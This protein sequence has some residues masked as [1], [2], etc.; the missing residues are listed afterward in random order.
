LTPAPPIVSVAT[1]RLIGKPAVVLGWTRL[2]GESK[3]AIATFRS[4]VYATCPAPID[5]TTPIAEL[6]SALMITDQAPAMSL[7]AASAVA[8]A[9]RGNFEA[10]GG[11]IAGLY[12]ETLVARFAS[13]P[14]PAAAI[15]PLG[16]LPEG[17]DPKKPALSQ[18]A[19]R[20]ELS[21]KW[22]NAGCFFHRLGA[23]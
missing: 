15:A 3:S 7:A 4:R 16:D 14:A 9:E 23:Q 19:M 11:Q 18:A 2:P 8:G 6:R 13:L 5:L 12:L 17:I 22:V 10:V 21:P 20:F 1:A